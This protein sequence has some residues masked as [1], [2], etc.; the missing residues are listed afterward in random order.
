VNVTGPLML[1]SLAEECHNFEGF[2]QISTLFT[3]ADKTGFIDEKGYESTKD[4]KGEY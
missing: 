3:L 1:M 4:W 2:C